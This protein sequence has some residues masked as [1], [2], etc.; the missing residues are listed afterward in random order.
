MMKRDCPHENFD[1]SDTRGG[2]IRCADCDK[3]IPVERALESIDRRLK[4]LEKTVNLLVMERVYE[5][6]AD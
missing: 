6:S 2:F 4:Q 5:N 3:S 1:F